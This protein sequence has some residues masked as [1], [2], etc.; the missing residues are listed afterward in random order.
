MPSHL[1]QSLRE[2]HT[3]REAAY[4]IVRNCCQFPRY[5]PSR[6][7]LS[8][9]HVTSH[10]LYHVPLPFSV[11]ITRVR[12]TVLLFQRLGADGSSHWRGNKN[13][14]TARVTEANHGPGTFASGWNHLI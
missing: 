4:Y 7:P 6:T 1:G 12:S 3:W 5:V 9:F 13:M 8:L 2:G 10:N 14:L 11:S